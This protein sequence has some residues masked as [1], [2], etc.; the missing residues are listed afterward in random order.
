M[1]S[2]SFAKGKEMKKSKRDKLWGISAICVSVIGI[3]LNVANVLDFEMTDGVKI[4]LSLLTFAAVIILIY[5]SL[6]KWQE[7]L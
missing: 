3:F 6:K 5:T 1:A 2:V 4:I 7:K